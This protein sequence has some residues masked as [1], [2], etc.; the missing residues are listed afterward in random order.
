MMVFEKNREKIKINR[1]PKMVFHENAKS[2]K[3]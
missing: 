1:G 2:E 3:T